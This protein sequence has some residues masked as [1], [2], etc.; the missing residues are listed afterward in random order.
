[1]FAFLLE[2]PNGGGIEKL[3]EKS[4]HWADRVRSKHLSGKDAWDS[5][6]TT[7]L[8]SLGCPLMALT[9]EEK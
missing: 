9:L 7:V 2:L 8:K 1:M 5:F 3:K 4:K 6:E